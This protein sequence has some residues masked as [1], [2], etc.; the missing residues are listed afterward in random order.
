[1]EKLREINPDLADQLIPEFKSE[2]SFDSAFKLTIKSGEDIPLN[3]RGSGVR[4]LIL[5]SFF[6]AEAERIISG[7]DDT[8]IIYDSGVKSITPNWHRNNESN[9]GQMCQIM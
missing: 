5:L 8:S 3:K 4:R 9:I 7:T 2:P 6:R 1:L